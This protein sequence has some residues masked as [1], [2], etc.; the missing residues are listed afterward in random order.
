M[1]TNYVCLD[2][3]ATNVFRFAEFTTIERS[4]SDRFTD[5]AAERALLYSKSL[6]RKRCE[7]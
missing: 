5:V 3:F 1:A 6:G 4:Y 2:E 7:R